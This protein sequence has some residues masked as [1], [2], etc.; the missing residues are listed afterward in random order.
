MRRL[1]WQRT[2]A[3]QH[4]HTEHYAMRARPFASHKI[5][6]RKFVVVLSDANVVRFN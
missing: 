6:M 5:L 3:T 1:L 2:E 4:K